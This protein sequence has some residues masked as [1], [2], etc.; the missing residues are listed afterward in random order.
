MSWHCFYDVDD[1]GVYL[2]LSFD[3]SHDDALALVTSLL[4]WYAENSQFICAL[5]YYVMALLYCYFV[6]VKWSLFF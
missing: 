6:V 2:S 1:P 4:C 5:C 3:A